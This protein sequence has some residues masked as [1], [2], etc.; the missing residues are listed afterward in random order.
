MRVLAV[1]NGYQVAGGEDVVFASECAVL[2][3]HGHDVRQFTVTNDSIKGIPGKFLAAVGV[4]FSVPMYRGLRQLLKAWRPDVV[5]VHNFF[6]LISPAVF[7]ACKAEGVPVVMTLHNYRILCPTALLMHE[8]KVTERSLT[9]GPWWGVREKVYR[10]SLLGT[11][12]LVMMIALHNALGTWR[13]KVDRLIVLTEFARAKFVQAGLPPEKLVQKPNFTNSI[14]KP[15]ENCRS[16]FLYVGRFSQEK[17]VLLLARASANVNAPVRIAGSGPLEKE[18]L[19][20]PNLDRLGRLSHE[21]AIH[22]I[23][24]AMAL[25][26]PSVWYE[27]FPMVVVEAFAAGTPVIA[28]RI[29]SLAELIEDGVTGLLFEPGNA[30]ELQAKMDW[31]QAHPEK[32]RA[33]GQAARKRYEALYTADANYQRL[34][35]I[36]EDAITAAA[37]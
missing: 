31:A 2:K 14:S 15:P 16:G 25:V 28:S 23:G 21:Q 17:G 34:I 35:A 4:V 10:G 9:E 7:Y 26:L 30:E 29:G 37:A 22:E 32:M 18:L 11:S 12:M 20:W 6:P 8:G 24:R 1:H 3:E 33:M 5:H 27:G 13:T 19:A 36:Y